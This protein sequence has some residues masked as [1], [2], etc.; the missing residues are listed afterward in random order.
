[1]FIRINGKKYKVYEK[2]EE[3]NTINNEAL[4]QHTI[5]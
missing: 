2:I 4:I 1:M 3:L 5:E